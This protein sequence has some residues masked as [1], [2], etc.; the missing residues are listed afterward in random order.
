MRRKGRVSSLTRILT[1][2][3]P[4]RRVA[5][6]EIDWVLS[7]WALG[8]FCLFCIVFLSVD[9]MLL[10]MDFGPVLSWLWPSINKRWKKEKK[11]HLQM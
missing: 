1:R 10:N 8:P 7:V 6:H 9:L 11:N 4:F 5:L 2:V 3:R